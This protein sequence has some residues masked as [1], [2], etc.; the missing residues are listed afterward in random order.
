L[1]IALTKHGPFATHGLVGAGRLF[2]HTDPLE[3]RLRGSYQF[4][5]IDTYPINENDTVTIRF[6]DR[7]ASTV[8]VFGGGIT[9]DFGQRHGVRADLR[10]IVGR[11]G[12]G[13]SLEA[14]ASAERVAP[15][16][17]LPSNTNPS[18]QFST[19]AADRSS[20]NGSIAELK[21]FTG[22]G[23]DTRILFT[24]GYFVRF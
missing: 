2:S 9:S 22:S 13:T 16:L 6:S 10:V 17:A 21:T 15:F 4:R 23:L 1:N 8:G 3:A 18:V 5:F 24:V 11:S 20:L 19:T 7:N 12:L 14:S